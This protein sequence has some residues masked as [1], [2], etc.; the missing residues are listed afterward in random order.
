MEEKEI[1]EISV[2]NQAAIT[3]SHNPVFHEKTKHFNIKLYFLREVQKNGDVIL[4]YYK[5]KDQ[6]D[7]LFTKPLPISRFEFLRQK[8]GICSF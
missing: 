7:N 3:L 1:I 8:I 5:S 4:I 2:D 6:L